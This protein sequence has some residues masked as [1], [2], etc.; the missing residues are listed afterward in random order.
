MD[1]ATTRVNNYR[2]TSIFIAFLLRSNYVEDALKLKD[3]RMGR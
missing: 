3:N 2:I 1:A